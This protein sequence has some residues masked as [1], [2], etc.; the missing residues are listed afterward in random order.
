MEQQA[1]LKLCHAGFF[2]VRRR[3][4]YDKG[5]LRNNAVR[6]GL[7]N[8]YTA[9]IYIDD[10]TAPYMPYTN[11]PWVSPKWR[12]KKNPNEFWFDRT[13]Q[14]MYGLVREATGVEGT[15]TD[16]PRK[17]NI[18]RLAKKFK[19]E[20]GDVYINSIYQANEYGLRQYWNLQRGKTP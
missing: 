18:P 15:R 8:T 16:K 14:S 2:L 12:G 4:P 6:I 20:Q 11:E 1:F 19:V 13:A 17:L 5:N 7:E 3:S 9:R 10:A